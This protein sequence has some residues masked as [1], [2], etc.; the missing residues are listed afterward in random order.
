MCRFCAAKVQFK[1]EMKYF[2]RCF[3]VRNLSNKSFCIRNAS[4]KTVYQ[5]HLFG[6]YVYSWYTGSRRQ[7]SSGNYIRACFLKLRAT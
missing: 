6:V 2:K 3:F 5:E 1:I 4:G 7:S